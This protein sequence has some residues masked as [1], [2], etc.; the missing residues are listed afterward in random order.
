M[1]LLPNN[2]ST[3]TSTGTAKWQKFRVDLEE[4]LSLDKIY[5]VYLKSFTITNAAVLLPVSI[6]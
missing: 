4:T 6:L 1:I 2:G 3:V 5:D